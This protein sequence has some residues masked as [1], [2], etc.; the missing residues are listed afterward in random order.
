MSLTRLELETTLAKLESK[1]RLEP[2]LDA[3]Y[4]KAS[5]DILI[6][7]FFD[8]KDI[9]KIAQKQREFLLR[10]TGITQHYS[11]KS[12]GMAHLALAPILS[13]HFDRR[14]RLLESTLQDFGLSPLEVQNWIRFEE[15]FRPIILK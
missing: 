7:F 3:F 9:K 6:A 15:V 13:G 5:Q 4:K 1:G 12:P 2:L 10:A 8:G 14:L 11:G